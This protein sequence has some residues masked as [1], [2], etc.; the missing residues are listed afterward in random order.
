VSD[1][2]RSG[3]ASL[4]IVSGTAQLQTSMEPGMQGPV[5]SVA[6]NDGAGAFDAE[7]GVAGGSITLDRFMVEELARSCHEFLVALD[8]SANAQL[9][10]DWPHLSG[11]GRR[12][13]VERLRKGGVGR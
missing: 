12:A 10:G 2:S 13:A 3:T 1:V 9:L 6:L 11:N 4:S 7:S 8:H 5:L